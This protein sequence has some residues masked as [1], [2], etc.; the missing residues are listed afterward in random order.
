MITNRLGHKAHHG[1]GRLGTKNVIGN[2]RFVKHAFVDKPEL[3]GAIAGKIEETAGRVSKVAG[4]GAG[5]AGAVG[6]VPVA[7]AL[8][9]ISA[10]AGAVSGVAG[11]VRQGAEKVADVKSNFNRVLNFMG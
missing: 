2:L 10:G 9:G 3:G 1:R 11:Q 6:A 7:G 4:I 5:I 8:G